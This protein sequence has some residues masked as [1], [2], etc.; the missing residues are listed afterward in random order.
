MRR[1]ATV[2]ALVCAGGCGAS[3]SGPSPA[4][5]SF[6]GLWAGTYRITKCDS[7]RHCVESVGTTQA[8][9][10]RLAQAGAGVS[11]VFE[12]RGLVVEVGGVSDGNGHVTLVGSSGPASTTEPGTVQVSSFSIA[13]D[14]AL[15]LTG[16]VEYTESG[17]EDFSGTIAT[18]SYAATVVSATLRPLSDLAG[19]TGT[20][21][22]SFVVRDSAC[23]GWHG[24][25]YPDETGSVVPLTLTITDNGDVSGQVTL[26]SRVV[27]VTGHAGSTLQLT[28]EMSRAGSGGPEVTRILA[29]TAT[30]DR[31]GRLTGTLRY[32][33][34]WQHGSPA[35]LSTYDAEL[36]DV[37]KDP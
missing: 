26:N 28:G 2:I 37:I 30:S 36:F 8:F 11:G 34:E 17:P 1:L 14:P 6:Q 9:T 18:V 29:F 23:V 35:P 16:A 13:L 12:T 22:G 4:V 24:Y 3:P 15:G 5:A 25:C 20:W 27:P 21:R 19:W 32:S 10:L 31:F 7:R 33:V